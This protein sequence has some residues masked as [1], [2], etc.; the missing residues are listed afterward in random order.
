MHILVRRVGVPEAAATAV[1]LVIAGLD[2]IVGTDRSVLPL[3]VL[4]PVLAVSGRADA[5]RPLWVAGATVMLAATLG[6]PNWQIRPLSMGSMLVGVVAMGAVASAGVRLFQR[7]SRVLDDV[8]ENSR[9]ARQMMKRIIQRPVPERV[10]SLRTEVRY[11]GPA[12]A[13]MP[14]D[15][16]SVEDTPF[17]VRML[18]GDVAG[19]GG[20]A[21]GI[22]TEVSCAF[23]GGAWTEE[24]LPL[25]AA[26]LQGVLARSSPEE[27]IVTALFVQVSGPVVSLL[28]CGHPPPVLLRPA[29]AAEV[30]MR[31]SPPLGLLHLGDGRL[32]VQQIRLDGA[33]RLLLYTDGVT[34]ARDEEGRPFPL[35]ARAAALAGEQDP[36]AFLDALRDDLLRHTGGR[37]T[38]DAV[39]LLVQ[40]DQAATAPVASR[41]LSATAP[42]RPR[43]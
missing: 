11:L 42:A 25:L 17:G 23:R 10:R 30:E 31:P 32:D 26:H 15:M 40:M 41:A 22:S 36:G 19:R 28:S 33:D 16:C 35:A 1:A 9:S 8:Q 6:F 2:A 4:V 27:G 39:L 29:G 18:V 24:R 13:R 3:Y 21:F 5:R 38:D 14:A 43:A 12:D 37:P 34:G 20:A 7:Q